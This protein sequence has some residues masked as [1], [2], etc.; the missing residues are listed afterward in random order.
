M[1]SEDIVFT[2]GPLDGRRLPILL[3]LNGRPPKTYEVP[4][5]TVAD[6]P[7]TVLVYRLEAVETTR[8]L[9]LPRRWR[10][11]YDPDAAP[12]E[13]PRVPWRRGPLNRSEKRS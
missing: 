9:R 11:V 8:M 6:R 7:A 10:Y 3:G 13:G 4:V 5:P 12:A 2:E 1:R